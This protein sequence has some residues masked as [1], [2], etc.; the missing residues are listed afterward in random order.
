[1]TVNS[2]FLKE[3]KVA[4]EH[5]Q[6]L[7]G[8]DLIEEQVTRIVGIQLDLQAES[9]RVLQRRVEQADQ[10]REVV[11]ELWAQVLALAHFLKVEN[12]TLVTVDEE[13]VTQTE[14]LD[15]YHLWLLFRALDE[16]FDAQFL[17]LLYGVANFLD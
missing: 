13:V 11:S 10:H 9:V 15:A 12:V 6:L 8:Q 3:F 17:S 16:D 14:Q 5:L 2:L 7:V 4:A 1:M